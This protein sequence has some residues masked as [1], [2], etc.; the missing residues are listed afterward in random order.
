MTKK[1]QLPALTIHFNGEQALLDDIVGLAKR[2]TVD[3]FTVGIYDENSSKPEL[4]ITAKLE[5]KVKK[6]GVKESSIKHLTFKQDIANLSL[7]L[8]EL[9]I[10][11]LLEV[12]EEYKAQ[13]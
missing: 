2:L 6:R 10:T 8:V 5:Q 13:K 4:F 1:K 9:K 12:Y 7:L 11:S 3:K